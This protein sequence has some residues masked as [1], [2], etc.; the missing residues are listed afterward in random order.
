[1]V[2]VGFLNQQYTGITDI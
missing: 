2:Q 1:M